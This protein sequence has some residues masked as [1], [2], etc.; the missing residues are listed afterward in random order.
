MAKKSRNKRKRGRVQTKRTSDRYSRLF[1]TPEA[2]LSRRRVNEEFEQSVTAVRSI[3]ERYRSI[4]AAVAVAVSDLWPSN[5]ASPIKHLLFLSVLAGVEERQ[6]DA[7]PI[8]TYNEFRD[9]VGELIAACPQFPMLE[10]YVPETD[11]GQVKILLQ[12]APV[13]MFYGSCIERTPDFVEAFRITQAGNSLALADMDLAI[14]IQSHV[15]RSMPEVGNRSDVEVAAGHIEVPPE[16]FWRHC[17]DV[18][19]GAQNELAPWRIRASGKLDA[20]FGAYTPSLS[21]EDFGNACMAGLAFPFLGIRFGNQWIPVAVRAA[22]AGAIDVWASSEKNQTVDPAAHRM[23]AR[24]VRERF[25]DALPGPLTIR[26]DGQRFALPI[27]CV[28]C[29]GSSVLLISCCSHDGAVAVERQALRLL[30]ELKQGQRW[31]LELPSGRFLPIADGNGNSPPARDVSVL[32]VTSQASTASG[33]INMPRKPIRLLPLPDFITLFDAAENLDELARFWEYSDSQ[34]GS[35]FP[36]SR[37]AADL[38]ASFRDTHEVL[39]GGAQTPTFISLDP[40]WGSRWR[41]RMLSEFWEQ[42]PA[43]F[44]DGSIGWLIDGHRSG[45]IEMKS[46]H[47]DTIAYSLVV[48]NC[49]VQVCM[50]INRSLS[51]LENRMLDMFVQVLS[52][53]LH[54]RRDLLADLALFEGGHLLIHCAVDP[55]CRL[56]EA[57]LSGRNVQATP[58]VTSG[59]DLS[60]EALSI[61]LLV[62]PV[63]VQAGLLD[64]KDGTFEAQ[65]LVE[66]LEMIQGVLGYQA[67]EDLLDSLLATANRLPRYHLAVVQ[68]R[69]DVLEYVDPIVPSM[70]DYKMARRHLAVSMQKLGVKPGRYELADAKMV[71]DLGKNFLLRHIDQLIGRFDSTELTRLCMEQYDA[72]L[73]AERRKIDRVRQSL[74]HEVDYDRNAAIAEAR[75]DLGGTAKHYRYLIEKVVSAASS[76]EKK[77]VD[78]SVLRE[79]V[80]LIDWYMVM[81]GASDVLH[82]GVEVGGVDI[83]DSYIPEVFYSS[84]WESQQAYF[85]KMN[86]QARMGVGVMASDVVSGDAAQGLDGASLGQAFRHDVGFDLKHLLQSLIVLSQ[87]VRLGFAEDAALTYV[88]SNDVVREYILRNIDGLSVEECEAIVSFLTLSATDI[89]RLPGRDVDEIDVPFWEHAKRLHRYNLRPLIAEGNRLRWGAEHTSRAMYLWNKAIVDG[90]LPADF[91]WPKVEEEVRLIKEDIER[92][93]EEKAEEIF[94]RFTPHVVR[95]VDFFRRFPGERFPDVGDFDVLAYWPDSNTLVAVECKYNKPAFCV[96][97]SRRL[98]DLIFGTGVADRR[99]HFSKIERRREF[100]GSNW[101]LLQDLLGWPSSPIATRRDVEVYVT[102]EMHWWL[103]HPPYAVPTQFVAVEMLDSWL[104]SQ[105]WIAN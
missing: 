32:L 15:I 105:A 79:L 84:D 65:C 104:R 50:R 85:A 90:Y 72:I 54:Q 31:G 52:D 101:P 56:D 28:I 57:N 3:L 27:S 47:D 58:V 21:Y 59:E 48:A 44:P 1:D 78:A 46:R 26:T 23:L 4:D 43:C 53:G 39:V 68:E 10:D 34:V 29:P 24:F 96:K 55:D 67:P 33:L 66:A 36:L 14:A 81:A 80:G 18:L 19:L 95:G 86:A 35:I 6:Q 88:A 103:V 71:I 75:H 38:F 37:G 25:V 20:E 11:W 102:R 87:P 42:A 2:R 45:V 16:D 40:S 99:S 8:V 9:F 62:S 97:D 100:A 61:G 73:T 76:P 77:A 41:Y 51:L 60:E 7:L 64:A 92:R 63:S 30:S 13:P 49:T 22:P 94:R 91:S 5:A 17:R 70:T 82:H 83:D 69:V 12:G 74:A 98:R 93:L 89:R